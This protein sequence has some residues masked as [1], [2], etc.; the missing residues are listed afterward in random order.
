MK[1]LRNDLPGPLV[2][3]KGMKPV[4]A[5]GTFEVDEKRA[6]ALLTDPNVKVSA[7]VRKSSGLSK[8]NKGELIELAAER[9]I[10]VSDSM[11]IAELIEAIEAAE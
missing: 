4:P 5:G 8:L 9:E 6:E 10:E 1:T 7:A 2:P 11:T 3:D